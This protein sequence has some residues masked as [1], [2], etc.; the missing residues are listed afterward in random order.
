MRRRGRD[1]RARPGPRAS[2]ATTCS[3]HSRS[4]IACGATPWPRARRRPDSARGRSRASKPGVPSGA[5][6]STRTTIPQ[7]ANFDELDAISY[8]KGCYIGQEVVARVHFRG[9]VNRHLRGLRAASTDA[10]PHRRAAHRRHRQSRRRRAQLGVVAAARRHRDRHGSARGEPGRVA[11]GASGSMASSAST[12]RRF[13]SRPSAACRARSS[14]ARTGLVGSHIVERL[15]R[16]GWTVRALVRSHSRLVETLGVECATGDV[17]DADAFARAARGLRRRSFTP[18]RRSRRS[19]GWEAFRRPNVDGTMQRD[20]RRASE[21]RAAR[22]P[23][24]R[25]RVRSGRAVSRRR[26]RRPTKTTPLA[27]LPERAYY[28]RSKRESEELVLRAHARRARSGRRRCVPTVIYGR[29]DRQFV[30][31]VARLLSRGIVA[32]HRRRRDRRSRSCTR[33]TSPTASCA[34][35]RATRAAGRAYNLAND[36][37][38]TVRRLLRARGERDSAGAFG[39]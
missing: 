19:G 31:R 1:D 18:R 16:D 36:F 26:A 10:P 38:V 9:H 11:D 6:T 33:R 22:P 34:P 7:E 14:P 25:R 30:P 15:L 24:Q 32:A 27:P 3:C 2:R 20:R 29:R 12:S 35:P 13:P 21:R 17:L 37:D 28:A 4:S 5:S 23:E 39:S 8:T